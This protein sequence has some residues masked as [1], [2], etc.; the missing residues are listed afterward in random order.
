MEILPVEMVTLALAAMAGR[1][2]GKFRLAS[3]IT[4]TE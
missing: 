3:K 2:P 1:E 4:T